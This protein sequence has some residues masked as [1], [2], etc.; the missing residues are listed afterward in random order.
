MAQDMQGS[1][2]GQAFCSSCGK[3]VSQDARFCPYCG[4][5]AA[6]NPS[7]C[8]HC[9]AAIQPGAHFC[10]GCGAAVGVGTA[11]TP[12]VGV[13]AQVEVEYMG[14]WI[15][16]VAAII[17][18]AL[19]TVAGGVLGLLVPSHISVFLG[20]VYAVLFIGLRGQTLGKMA[21]G[22]KVVDANGDVPGIGRAALREI[23]GK[24]VSAIVIML[25]YLWVGWDPQK[26]AWHDHIAG[27]YVVRS[28][29]R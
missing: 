5:G 10:P 29:P 20:W 8:A 15:R 18:G 2:A 19:V 6:P 22:I 23:V 28:K 21:L 13:G 24:F 25:G 27:T 14:F 17:D 26:R 3:G 12:V 9:G 7:F 11:P 1:G 16:L 4:Q